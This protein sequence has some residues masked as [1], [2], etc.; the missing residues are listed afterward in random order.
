[1]EARIVTL[2]AF[3]AILNCCYT[4][5]NGKVVVCNYE[6][7]AHLREGQGKFDLAALEPALQY[8]THLI[9]GYAAIKEDTLKLV[10]L[11]EQFD[12]IRDNYRHVTNLKVKYPNLKVIL[13]V[14]G[15]EDV[16]GEGAEKNLKY[17]QVLESSAHRLAFINSAHTLVKGFGFD[18]IDLAWEFP[19]TKPKKI[20]TG[21]GKFWSSVKKTFSGETVI[22]EKAE[23]HRDQFTSL[24]RELKTAFKPD[25]FLITLT[26]LPN[27]NSTVYYDPRGLAPYVD[28]VTL[29][30]FDFYTPQR[31]PKLAD[32]PAPLYDLIDRRPDEN[33]DAWI[34]YWLNNGFPVNKLILGI[35]TYGRTWKLDEDAKVDSVPPEGLDGAGAPGPLTKDAG[36]LSYPEVCLKIRGG[37][38]NVSPSGYRKIPD[39]T[40][41]KGFYAYKL[42]DGEKNEE[43]VWIAY[44]DPQTAASKGAYVKSKGLAGIA[45]DDLTLDDFRG[46]CSDNKYAI[47]KAAVAAL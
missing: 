38:G 24:I 14:G 20:K 9:Y 2:L 30:A 28:F 15:N 5:H 36:I 40:N 18:G 43:G 3:F 37:T 31:N 1:M 42:P 26:V 19:E 8:C 32:F 47:L 27:V 6:T 23:E 35:P 11:N 4:L 46:V 25:N 13:S 17:R 33:V 16:T 34:K 29:Q 39:A 7:K 22:D 41:K 12:V 10:P 45:L 44:E 21:F